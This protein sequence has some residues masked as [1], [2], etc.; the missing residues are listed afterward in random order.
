M[1]NIQIENK[2]NKIILTINKKEMDQDYLIR[3]IKRLET[4]DLVYKSGM[5]EQSL[6]IAEDIKQDWWNKN[7]NDFLKDIEK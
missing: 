6:Q 3:L 2:K 7:K 4:E 1:Q 5:N